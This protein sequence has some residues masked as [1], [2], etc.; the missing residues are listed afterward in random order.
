MNTKVDRKA[1]K[2]KKLREEIKTDLDEIHRHQEKAAS[3][4][5]KLRRKIS[6]YEQGVVQPSYL[7]DERG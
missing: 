5:K 7:P 2:E 6:D 1:S 4:V 3:L